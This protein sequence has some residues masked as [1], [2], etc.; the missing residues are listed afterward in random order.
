MEN[1]SSYDVIDQIDIKAPGPKYTEQ[2]IES[3]F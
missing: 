3:H 1:L 2:R